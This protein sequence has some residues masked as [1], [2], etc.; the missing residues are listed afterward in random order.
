VWLRLQKTGKKCDCNKPVQKKAPCHD[1]V[2]LRPGENT[3]DCKNKLKC[4]C[5]HWCAAIAKKVVAKISMCVIA[6]MSCVGDCNLIAS[7]I[8]N[9]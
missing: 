3:G 7:V 2:R 6:T 9:L 4:G 5:K 1:T 8:A